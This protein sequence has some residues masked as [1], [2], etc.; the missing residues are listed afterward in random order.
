MLHAF[1][2]KKARNTVKSITWS[3]LSHPSL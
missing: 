3:E 2:T 1:S